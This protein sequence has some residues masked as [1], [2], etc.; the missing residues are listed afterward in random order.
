M[1]STSPQRA[2]SVAALLVGAVIV[3]MVLTGGL[4]VTP[5]GHAARLT[6][7]AATTAATTAARAD[8]PTGPCTVCPD[9]ASLADKVVPAVISVYTTDVVTQKEMRQY[10]RNMDPFEFFFGPQFGPGQQQQQPQERRGAGSGFFISADGLALTNNHVVEGADTIKVQLADNT[11]LPAKIVGRDPATDIAL[12]KVEGKGPFQ[13]LQLGD[14]HT[15]KVGAWVMAVGNPLNMDHTVTVGVVSAKGRTLGLLP[16]S[17]FENY[18]QTDAAINLGNSGGPLVNLAGEVVGINSAINAAGQNLGFAVP[19]NTA[20]AILPQL[21]KKGRVV[22]GYLG[23][24]ITNVTDKD[25]K[26]FDLPAREGALVQDVEQDGPAAKAGLKAGD[27]VVTL[28]GAPVKD[29]RQLID[30]VSMVAPGGKV[31]L[32]VIRDGKK[33]DVTVTVG[34]RPGTEGQQQEQ[35]PEEQ[36]ATDRLGLQIDDISP[37]VRR[38]L[39]L[40]D[41]VEGVVITD[42]RNLSPADEANLQE[43]EVITRVNGVAV[44]S[45]SEVKRELAKIHSGS[46]VRLYVFVPQVGRSS[47]FILRMP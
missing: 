30:G 24:Y 2:I 4:G 15:L 13:A 28:D 34:E 32:G 26:A 33:L 1:Q 46:L 47:F 16:E 18:I 11:E 36:S 19:I 29:T 43:G 37:R 45:S 44:K 38:Q 39:Q 3:G 35:A 17:S 40:P 8:A 31:T 21:E 25:Q 20:K 10:H 6:P 22:R 23:V 41:D 5:D 7:A 42:V 27:A 9:F 14:S 12:I